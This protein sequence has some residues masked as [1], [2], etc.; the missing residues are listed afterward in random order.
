IC[1]WMILSAV[2]WVAASVCMLRRLPG[3]IVTRL[4]LYFI[5]AFGGAFLAINEAAGGE[6]R[7]R[8]LFERGALTIEEP[9]EIWGTLNDAP[10]LAP[11]RIYL[12]V[13]VERV[14]TL[15]RDRAAT[16]VTQIVAPRRDDQSRD[17]FDRPSFEYCFR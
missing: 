1:A 8:K 16:G 7:M 15:G 14:A 11:D 5:M 13:A 2:L 4:L 9:V 3:W 12:S 17:D 10:E 6:D